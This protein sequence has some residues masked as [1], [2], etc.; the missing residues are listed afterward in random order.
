MTEIAKNLKALRKRCGLTIE[1]LAERSGVSKPMISQIERGQS[2][3]TVTTLWKLAAG[4]KCPLTALLMPDTPPLERSE[5]AQPVLEADGNMKAWPLFA[6]DPIRSL[7]VFYIRFE[8]GCRHVSEG[9][10]DGVEEY[11]LPA[12]GKLCVTAGGRTADAEP[13]QALRFRADGAHVY[14]NTGEKACSVYNV[15]VYPAL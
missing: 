14:E 7:E 12:C 6:Y 13:G 1:R 15:I 11:I 3:P 5:T 10:Q 8:P 2:M 4:L 9:H